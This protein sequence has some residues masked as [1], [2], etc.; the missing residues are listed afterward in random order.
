MSSMTRTSAGTG[1]TGAGS[2]PRPVRDIADDF[3]QR[4]AG[5]DPVLAT[6]LGLPQGQDELPDL[7]PAG[8]EAQAELQRATLARLAEEEK[9]AAGAG[10]L[11]DGDERRCAR[12][13]RERL[14]TEL[15][16]SATGE[17]RRSRCAASS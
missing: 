14:E 3:V 13:L 4:L 8:D 1:Q 16:I 15:A 10:G 12:L 17:N 5:L 9:A 7:S 11:A 6:H 2:G